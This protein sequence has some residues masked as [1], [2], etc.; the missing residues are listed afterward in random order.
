MSNRTELPALRSTVL[1]ATAVLASVSAT[2]CSSVTGQEGEA[3]AGTHTEEELHEALLP[4]FQD[5]GRVA[6]QDETGRYAEL[7]AVQQNDELREEVELNKPEC[8]DAVEQWTQMDAVRSAPSALAS[9]GREGEAITHA[10]LGVDGETAADV[11][12][13]RPP[14]ECST[15][16]ATDPE[17]SNTSYELEELDVSELD[18]AYALEV[19]AE[20]D[21]HSIRMYSLVYRG[22]EHVGMTS[23]LGP[24]ATDETL[25]DF[26]QA[27][28]EHAEENLG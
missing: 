28:H 27:A 25:V 22:T 12:A 13:T 1:A 15:Y 21:D 26:A 24:E 5:A 4:E 16:E 3:A 2:S 20:G 23:V 11:V 19:H 17:G 7:T 9:Y 10:L 6:E 18:D 14:D 8:L